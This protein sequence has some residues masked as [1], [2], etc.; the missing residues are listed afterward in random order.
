LFPL[1]HLLL[2]SI[3]ATATIVSPTSHRV[4]NVPGR[5]AS[6][7][8]AASVRAVGSGEGGWKTAYVFVTT[9]KTSASYSNSNGTDESGCGYFAHLNGWSA[10]W[11]SIEADSNGDGIEV[12][13]QRIGSGSAS[14]ISS[15][16]IHPTTT[17]AEVASVTPAD[18]AIITM[19]G[20]LDVETNNLPLQFQVDFDGGL[21]TTDTG[22]SYSGPPLH[23]FAIF[24]NPMDT[25]PSPSDSGVTTVHPGDPIPTSVAANT[26]LYFAAGVHHVPADPNTG[27]RVYALPS[28]V[29]V[30]LDAGAV[31]HGAVTNGGGNGK[32]TIVLE[33][34][35]TL[36]GED[37]PRCP[38]HGNYPVFSHTDSVAGAAVGKLSQSG[39]CKDNKSP[40]GISLRNVKHATVRGVTFVDFPNH[41]IIASAVTIKNSDGSCATTPSIFHNSKVWG[42]RANG[43]G[44]HV[45]GTWKV[46]NMFMRT[47]DDSMYTQSTDSVG[48]CPATTFDNVTSWNDA[49]G[50]GCMVTGAGGVMRDSANIYA[51]AS[52]QWW[53]G[54]RILS[55]RQ[56]GTTED[57]IISNYRAEDPL[58]SLNVFTIDMRNDASKPAGSDRNGAGT[59]HNV[60]FEDIFIANVSTVR[61]SLFSGGC[62][63]ACG[64]GPLPT[65]VP[66]TLSGGNQTTQN[67][68]GVAF[69]R[70]TVAG[71]PLGKALSAHPGLFNM[72]GSVCNVTVDGVPLSTLT[73]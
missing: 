3:V 41:H 38:L 67:I 26:T 11:L 66:N 10:S 14:Q 29:R 57:V 44:L 59:F 48:E 40:Q 72:S 35:G 50:S 63:P 51:R 68:S 5:A 69:N 43:D 52:W 46:S 2:L 62:V 54:G 4:A 17:S 49:N 56:M 22:P 28:D 20:P 73:A 61:K 70:V 21:Q 13:V 36:S 58:P 16:S 7:H 6:T 19:A 32:D 9:A 1:M 55:H 34:Y 23:T 45:F 30:Y 24:V 71:T 65:G 53:A 47:Q 33:G 64:N 8:Y 25:P 60:L 12:K 31:V 18:G 27:W 15:A 39:C 42:W 37:Q